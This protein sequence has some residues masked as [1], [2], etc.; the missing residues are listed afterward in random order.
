MTNEELKFLDLEQFEVPGLWRIWEKSSVKTVSPE[1]ANLKIPALILFYEL[2]NC[3]EMKPPTSST[4]TKNNSKDEQMK[5]RSEQNARILENLCELIDSNCNSETSLDRVLKTITKQIVKNGI[6][7]FF[8][9]TDEC[10][11]YFFTIIDENTSIEDE[12]QK[13]VNPSTSSA[14]IKSTKTAFKFETSLKKTSGKLLFE[15]F[16]NLF[17]LNRSNM[18][19]Y[20]IKGSSRNSSQRSSSTVIFETSDSHKPIIELVEKMLSLSANLEEGELENRLIVSLVDLLDSIQSNLLYKVRESLAAQSSR[21][22]RTATQF[23]DDY[24][25][26][27]IDKSREFIQ[28]RR[29]T[30]E[31][32]FF[33]NY[34][35]TKLVYNFVLWLN[36]ILGLLKLTSSVKF[37]NI[38]ISLFEL[39]KSLNSIIPSPLTASDS[40]EK[41]LRT[42]TF[43]S[44]HK[45]QIFDLIVNYNYPLA[46]RFVIDFE[47]TSTLAF[48]ESSPE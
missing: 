11:E 48:S 39:V 35:F 21:H 5:M 36:E 18:V 10:R 9:S 26:L 34:L 27:L 15:A 1:I 13:E 19:Q 30:N 17:C 24:A 16:C 42:W 23:V 46:N 44:K 38:L 3:H 2:V 22:A 47:P 7:A 20:L 33:L 32:G 43:N 40:V 37:T 12:S 29:N 28:R 14:A 31:I 4:E 6:S 45:N 41:C 8:P 25:R